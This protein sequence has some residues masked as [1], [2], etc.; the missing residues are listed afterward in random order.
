VP[1]TATTVTFTYRIRADASAVVAVVT[2]SN[3]LVSWS[4][5]GQS[6]TIVNQ[7]APHADGSIVVT[8]RLPVT[9]DWRFLRVEGHAVP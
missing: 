9:D 3:D 2:V 7:S 6:L 1:G 8:A 4:P 5:A